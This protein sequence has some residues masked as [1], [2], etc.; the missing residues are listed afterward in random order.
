[1][2]EPSPTRDARASW[3]IPL[4]PDDVVGPLQIAIPVLELAAIR[5]ADMLPVT[6]AEFDLSCVTRSHARWLIRGVIVDDPTAEQLR[7][8]RP[9]DRLL[10]KKS[11]KRRRTLDRSQ[12]D[13]NRGGLRRMPVS[14]PV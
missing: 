12:V 10:F 7:S 9:G 3:A 6:P 13:S 4:A 11:V 14:M 2:A 5:K 1:M 8:L